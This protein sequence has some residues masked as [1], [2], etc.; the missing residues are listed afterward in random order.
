[1]KAIISEG[2]MGH[3]EDINESESGNL[4][5]S[6]FFRESDGAQWRYKWTKPI[7]SERGMGHT[8]DIN[9]SESEHLN[10]SNLFR[11]RWGTVKI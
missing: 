7:V 6:N 4:N 11:E 1:M 9:E 5:E 8:E 2:G 3:S 10:E